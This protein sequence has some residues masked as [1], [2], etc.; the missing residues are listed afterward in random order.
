MSPI[1]FR[2]RHWIPLALTALCWVGLAA[3]AMAQE[4]G[5]A[6]GGGPRY[7]LPYMLVLLFIVLGILSITRS[8]RRRDKPLGQEKVEKGTVAAIPLFE[9]T[10]G[11]PQVMVGMRFADVAKVLGKPKVQRLGQD[12]YAELFQNGQL[13]E[14]D[15]AKEHCIFEHKAGRYEL[16][17]LD[18]KIVQIKRQPAPPQED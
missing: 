16:V 6:E 17:F 4:S 14:E 10:E 8:S 9:Q 11:A 15:A 1:K 5:G 18:K 13:S 7:V 12:I 2:L 3:V